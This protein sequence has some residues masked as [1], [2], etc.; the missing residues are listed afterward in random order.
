VTGAVVD[1]RT[2]ALRVIAVLMALRALTDVFKP[3]GAGRGLVFF[4][5]MLT[6]APMIVLAPLVGAYMLVYAYGLWRVRRFALPMGIA[7]AVLVT[8]NLVR[9]PMVNPMPPGVTGFRYL[10]FA[11]IGFGVSVSAVWLLA[12]ATEEEPAAA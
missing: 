10:I 2:T 8:I 11:A 9:F 6:G 1:R 5:S 3:L 4:G 7:Y 12:Q